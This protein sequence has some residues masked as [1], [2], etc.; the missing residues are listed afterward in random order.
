MKGKKLADEI[1]SAASSDEAKQLN[2]IK[3]KELICEIFLNE[4]KK[5]QGE[6]LAQHL[7]MPVIDTE[8]RELIVTFL[9]TL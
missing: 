7:V 6:D 5:I 9:F 8:K 3:Q 4:C 1:I 2:E